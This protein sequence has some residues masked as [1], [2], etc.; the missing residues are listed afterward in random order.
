MLIIKRTGADFVGWYILGEWYI[1]NV[2]HCTALYQLS[3]ML[4]CDQQ[5][6]R[7]GTQRSGVSSS[8]EQNWQ[9]QPAIARSLPDHGKVGIAKAITFCQHNCWLYFLQRNTNKK[10]RSRQSIFFKILESTCKEA[11]DVSP[12]LIPQT[13]PSRTLQQPFWF[14][15]DAFSTGNGRA[16]ENG[17]GKCQRRQSGSHFDEEEQLPTPALRSQFVLR[18]C[19]ILR[20]M[21]EISFIVNLPI[22]W[23]NISIFRLFWVKVFASRK[24][25]RTLRMR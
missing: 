5:R 2:A 13:Y 8:R 17:Q 24:H 9:F 20:V 19:V 11:H 25:K 7:S 10:L 4:L 6:F 1:L 14:E 12:P 22:H 21:R 18:W 16:Q 15:L 23:N 3:C